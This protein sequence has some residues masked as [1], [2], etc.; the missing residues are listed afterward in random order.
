MNMMEAS[1]HAYCDDLSSLSAPIR[2][3]CLIEDEQVV[4]SVGD[5]VGPKRSERRAGL[6]NSEATHPSIEDGSLMHTACYAQTPFS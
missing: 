1:G 4:P 3:T 5:G 6:G 2:R